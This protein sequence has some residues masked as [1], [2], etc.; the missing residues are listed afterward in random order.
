MM[1]VPKPLFRIAGLP[2]AVDWSVLVIATLLA[3]VLAETAL[4][5]M[6]PGHLPGTYWLAGFAGAVLLLLS[7]LA[8]ELAH[9][10]VA[11][12]SGVEVERLTLWVLGGIASLRGTPP[13]PRAD[14]RIAAV[15][16]A[17]SVGLGAGFAAVAV[18]LTAV[19]ASDLAVGVVVWLALANIVLAVF[20]LVPG[21]PLDGGRVLR[22]FLWHRWGDRVRAATA[23][24]TAGQAVA[25][26]LV[27]LAALSFL[28]GDTVGAVWLLLVAW[29]VHSAARAERASTVAEH[30]LAGV[31]VGAVM[32]KD[33]RTGPAHLRVGEFVDDYLL[34]GRHSAYPVVD[35]E[36]TVVGLVTLAQLRAVPGA[37]RRGTLV[38]DACLPLSRIA[39]TNPAEPLVDLLPRLTGES[40]GRALVFEDGHLVGIVTPAD[41]A[42]AVDSRQLAVR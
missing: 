19:D 22:A 2:V 25:S 15:G 23:A 35:R 16:P 40:G 41:V 8:H 18:A 5:E 14:F 30:V 6:A 1:A 7:V 26:G 29:F 37:H 4:P 3:W 20:N 9:A 27:V 38:R 36:G 34:G 10:L 39:V 42:R 33:I 21:A 31:P 17:I 32:S 12:R 13:T 28:A 11:R 24:T